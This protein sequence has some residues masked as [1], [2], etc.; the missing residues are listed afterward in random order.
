MLNP[1]ML[2]PHIHGRLPNAPRPLREVPPVERLG[3]AT[4]TLPP[5]DIAWTVYRLVIGL[6]TLGAAAGARLRRYAG[7]AMATFSRLSTVRRNVIRDT[8]LAR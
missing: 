6:E 3:T 7:G 4:G 1:Y 2:F 5:R 8:G